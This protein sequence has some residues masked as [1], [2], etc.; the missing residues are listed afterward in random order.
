MSPFLGAGAS[1]V[2]LAAQAGRER[3][4]GETGST[5]SVSSSSPVAQSPAQ[6]SSYRPREG[7]FEARYQTTMEIGRA[8]V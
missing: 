8:H 4:A 3:G 7:S 6:A 5:S 1:P 2:A